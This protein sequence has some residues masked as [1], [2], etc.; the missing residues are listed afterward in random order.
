VSQYKDVF[1]LYSL[2]SLL[3]GKDQSLVLLYVV[4]AEYMIGI[5]VPCP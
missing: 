1:Y 5:V 4:T 2:F 3:F